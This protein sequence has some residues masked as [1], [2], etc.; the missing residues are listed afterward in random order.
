MKKRAAVLLL[1]GLMALSLTA[2]GSKKTQPVK[3]GE[4]DQSQQTD[5]TE[6][7][8]QADGS[9]TSSTNSQSASSYVTLMPDVTEEM[10][11]ASYWSSLQDQNAGENIPSS[12]EQLATSDEIEAMNQAMLADSETAMYDLENYSQELSS[13]AS[14]LSSQAQTDLSAYAGSYYDENGAVITQD[15]INSICSNISGMSTGTSLQYAVCV[16]RSELKC[17]P[18]SK[19]ITDEAG[20]TNFDYTAASFVRVNEPALVLGS[21]ADGAF[22]YLVTYT[23]KGWVSR[24]AVAICSSAEEWKNA[25]QIDQSLMAV[26][27]TDKLYLESSNV[28]SASSNLLLTMGTQLEIATDSGRADTIGNRNAAQNLVVYIPTRTEDGSYQKTK[29][30]ISQSDLNEG[31]V[32]IGFLPMT[33]ENILNQ[34]FKYLG[35]SYGWGG[36]LNSVDC[37]G[38]A[39]DVYAC[40]GLMMPRDSSKQAASPAFSYDVS[41]SSDQDKKADLEQV[42]A[43]S[44]VYFPGHE[45]IYLGKANDHYYVISAVSTINPSD[46][47]SGRIRSV[48]ISTLDGTMRGSGNSWLGDLTSIQIPYK[49]AE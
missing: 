25:W 3:A 43:G 11:K 49:T 45:M 35:D 33:T 23:Y 28:D 9:S 2:C 36:M 13:L 7:S 26:I 15:M 34:S 8:D 30:L 27:T 18:T 40:F 31:N 48:V 47:G 10:T 19:I 4:E 5:G 21:S 1:A 16:K 41:G 20:D 24:D 38:L 32:S 42:P 22:Y 6:E 46:G 29:A 37:S 44:L 12:T 17:W 39:R 14:D